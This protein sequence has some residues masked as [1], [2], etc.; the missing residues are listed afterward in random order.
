VLIGN[1]LQHLLG[2]QKPSNLNT[3]TNYI[4]TFLLPVVLLLILATNTSLWAQSPNSN[5]NNNAIPTPPAPNVYVP[6]LKESITFVSN[7]IAKS[8]FNSFLETETT[9]VTTPIERKYFTQNIFDIGIYDN[10]FALREGK[11]K[12]RRADA[13]KGNTGESI[14]SELFVLTNQQNDQKLPQWLIFV[15]LGILS[16]MTILLSLYRKTVTSIFQA[17]FSLAMASNLYREQRSFIKIESFSSYILFSMSMGTLCFLLPQYLTDNSPFN[18]FSGLFLCVAGVGSI[19]VFRYFLLQLAAIILPYPNEIGFYNFIV[20]ITNKVIGYLL[21]P[22][23]FMLAYLPES[24]QQYWLYALLIILGIIY[25]YRN[26]R[27]L[28]IGGNTIIFHKFHFFVYLCTIEIAP[29]IILLKML[30]I[31]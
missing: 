17:F 22:A 12:K 6:T 2:Y 29:T 21:V 5:G 11:D 23:L 25:T 26:F 24:A 15:L 3:L 28:A 13:N 20:S 1:H 30:S 7:D 10:P 4:R 16:F 19:Y 8:D 14:W 9:I 27:G 31:F 18:T